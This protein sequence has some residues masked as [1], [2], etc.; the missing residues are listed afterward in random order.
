MTFPISLPSEED[1]ATLPMIDITPDGVW[2]PSN[3]NE[4]EKGLSFTDSH[5]DPPCFAQL[6]TTTAGDNMRLEDVDDNVFHNAV[7]DLPTTESPSNIEPGDPSIFKDA[8]DNLLPDAG[9]FLIP[10][11]PL[12]PLALSDARSTSLLT[13]SWLLTHLTLITS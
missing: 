5:F 9:H 11:T 8:Q 10:R 6:S 7:Q 3:F 1:L 13:P 4:T 12:T 2:C